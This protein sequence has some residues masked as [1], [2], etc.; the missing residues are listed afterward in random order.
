MTELLCHRIKNH[1]GLRLSSAP[2]VA[3]TVGGKGLRGT[4][5]E[6]SQKPVPS[7]PRPPQVRK[8]SQSGVESTLMEKQLFGR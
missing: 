1:R 3:E 4:G 2:L 5:G 7:V 8:S 6:A